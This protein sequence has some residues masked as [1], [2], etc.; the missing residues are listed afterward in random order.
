MHP[1]AR[2]RRNTHLHLAHTLALAA[3]TAA[4]T[5]PADPD[6]G[7]TAMTTDVQ[8]TDAVS[9]TTGSGGTEPDSAG[10]TSEATSTA[11]SSDATETSGSTTAPAD[12]STGAPSSPDAVFDDFERAELGGDWAVVFPPAPNDQVAIIDDSDLGMLP[13][14]QGFF[15]VNW[16]ATVFAADQYCEASIPTDVTDGWAHQVYVRWRESDGARYGFGYNNDPGQEFFGSW[17]FKYD[18]VPSEQTRVFATAPGDAPPAPG[19]DLRVEVEGFTLRGYHNGVLVLEATDDDPSRI[20]EGE[21]GLAARWA[22]GNQNTGSAAK[23]W[24][25]WGAGSL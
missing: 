9:E 17:Y 18:G 4:C 25:D 7:D 2:H 15:L 5:A 23:V 14:P 19:D 24:E 3:V 16:R 10:S 11:S 12:D 20:D 21:V 22:T 1:R 6:A 8:E 13:G